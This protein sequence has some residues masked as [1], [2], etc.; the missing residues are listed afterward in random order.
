MSNYAYTWRH[1]WNWIASYV[2]AGHVVAVLRQIYWVLI[3]GDDGEACWFCGRPYM[4]WYAPDDLWAEFSGN[5][6]LC[7]PSCFD[8]RAERAGVALHWK[9]ERFS[10]YIARDALPAR[11]SDVE[12]VGKSP[13]ELH[14]LLNEGRISVNQARSAQGIVLESPL[15]EDAARAWSVY[16]HYEYEPLRN[17]LTAKHI[18]EPPM[19]DEPLPCVI[20]GKGPDGERHS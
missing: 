17:R 20:C 13:E 1:G 6:G 10:D 4:L 16:D 5:S 2:R 8:K 3:R 11:M 15:A 18:Y 9:P 7:C 14:Q 19:S 12:L